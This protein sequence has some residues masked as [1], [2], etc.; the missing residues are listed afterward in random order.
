MNTMRID[1]ERERDCLKSGPSVWQHTMNDAKMPQCLLHN[2]WAAFKV[3][4]LDVP[5]GQLIEEQV[6]STV[7]KAG[8]RH[9]CDWV[10][11]CQLFISSLCI[12]A[13]YGI[14]ELDCTINVYA[15]GK[16]ETILGP[17]LQ[18]VSTLPEGYNNH[19]HE[20]AK[21]ANG[22]PASGPNRPPSQT[23]ATADIHVSPDG[24]FLKLGGTD[25]DNVVVFRRDRRSG[26]LEDSGQKAKMKTARSVVIDPSH[27]SEM[28]SFSCQQ[29]T[30]VD[31]HSASKL[32]KSCKMARWEQDVAR[33]L[34]HLLDRMGQYAWRASWFHTHWT[35]HRGQVHH[36]GQ[37]S[38]KAEKTHVAHCGQ[39]CSRAEGPNGGAGGNLDSVHM[40]HQDA[41]AVVLGDST[42]LVTL[43]PR[44]EQVQICKEGA[45][46][47]H[48]P[49][50]SESS[51]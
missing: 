17:I 35:Q 7:E 23:N 37:S 1:R 42:G 12:L 34:R 29:R 11:V 14:N 43:R 50:L 31:L 49:L 41:G 5:G 20:N 46:A 8:P 48:P 45:G 18:T 24:R 36:L 6:L 13:K 21:N 30:M 4:R 28:E 27:C 22:D 44:D 38:A 2:W 9:L 51:A 3:Y 40:C 25:S 10:A 26:K 32:D 16:D 15:F 39:P 33:H 47:R 19:D